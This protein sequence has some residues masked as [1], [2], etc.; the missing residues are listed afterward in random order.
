MLGGEV[1]EGWGAA[2]RMVGGGHRHRVG[3]GELQVTLPA[4][5]VHCIED[6]V[7]VLPLLHL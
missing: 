4:A 5:V 2:A 6:S 7:Q 1:V 3:A